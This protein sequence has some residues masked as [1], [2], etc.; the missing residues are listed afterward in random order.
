MSFCGL[1]RE[2]VL[3]ELGLRPRRFFDENDHETRFVHAGLQRDHFQLTRLP[4]CRAPFFPPG[5]L[6]VTPLRRTERFSFFAAAIEVCRGSVRSS[7]A[8]FVKVQTGPARPATS[9]V[10]VE[11]APRMNNL[12]IFIHE[13]GWRHVMRQQSAVK[14]PLRVLGIGTC[15]SAHR[16]PESKRFHRGTWSGCLIKEKVA[17]GRPD[18]AFFRK[19]LCSRD[20][21]W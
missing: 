5:T 4:R 16:P 18:E 14:L 7:S 1:A 12:Q 13:N 10:P 21:R 9:E 6:T 11:L 3:T 8:I 19:I 15:L 17:T 20:P 2:P